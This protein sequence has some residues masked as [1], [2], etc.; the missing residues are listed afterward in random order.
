MASGTAGSRM[1]SCAHP[2]GDIIDVERRSRARRCNDDTRYYRLCV[3]QY[4]PPPPR[5]GPRSSLPRFSGP[6]FFSPRLPSR[7]RHT[8]VVSPPQPLS[9]PSLVWFRARTRAVYVTCPPA[10]PLHMAACYTTWS[11]CPRRIPL[12]RWT[13]CRPPRPTGTWKRSA[14]CR[15]WTWSENRFAPLQSLS[16]PRA[17]HPGVSSPPPVGIPED[18]VSCIAIRGGDRCCFSTHSLVC[19]PPTYTES[20]APRP[21]HVKLN[22]L[23]TVPRYYT[24]WNRPAVRHQNGRRK[25][26]SDCLVFFAFFSRYSTHYCRCFFFLT[27]SFRLS[28]HCYC[29]VRTRRSYMCVRAA[30]VCSIP[31]CLGELNIDSGL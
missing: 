21:C 31:G 3:R 30:C 22:R 11:R 1:Q 19:P 10:W 13:T 8:C 9:K 16:K 12:R 5:R 20:L 17:S 6:L 4:P 14:R 15:R 26:C 7:P 29:C 18:N 2:T 27:L 24:E 28:F 23:T 25:A